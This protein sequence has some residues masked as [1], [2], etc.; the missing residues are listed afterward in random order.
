VFCSHGDV[1]PMLLGHFA[2]KGIDLGPEPQCPKG[3]TWALE[4]NK[5][6]DVTSA[7]YLPPPQE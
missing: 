2:S 3:S 1:I 4:T 5:A 7:R 6:G